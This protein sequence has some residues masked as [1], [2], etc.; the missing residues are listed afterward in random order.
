MNLE[1]RHKIRHALTEHI[2]GYKAVSIYLEM[3]YNGLSPILCKLA[4]LLFDLT[5]KNINY[6]KEGHIKEGRGRIHTCTL[7]TIDDVLDNANSIK[8]NEGKKKENDR[9]NWKKH[10]TDLHDQNIYYHWKFDKFYIFIMERE[11]GS[12]L[13]Y[14]DKGCVT[15]CTM[16]KI[17]VRADDMLGCMA[18]FVRQIGMKPDYD[19]IRNSFGLFIDGMVG[20]MHPLIASENLPRWKD[21]EDLDKYLGHLGDQ[22]EKLEKFYG[23]IDGPEFIDRLPALVRKKYLDDLMRGDKMPKDKEIKL[24]KE[25]VPSGDSSNLAKKPRKPREKKKKK[26]IPVSN[27]KPQKQS[28]NE[29][30][31]PFEGAP[32]FVRYYRAFLQQYSG[33]TRIQFDKFGCDSEIAAEVLDLLEEKGRKN[34]EFVNAWFEYFFDHKLKGHKIYKAN[35]TSMRELRYTFERFN[36]LF[37]I[38]Q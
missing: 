21:G 12:W 16:R 26:D 24:C 36:E 37:Y 17:L 20:K 10:I 9:S 30:L 11:L 3:A 25:I 6:K 2:K 29:A 13:C 28:Y 7:I 8:Y 35:N 19:A 31:N 23:L 34:K 33:N 1:Q 32:Y 15:P 18:L 5:I 14:N 4:H 38:P 27:G 22:L